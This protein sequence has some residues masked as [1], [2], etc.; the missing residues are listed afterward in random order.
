MASVA[1]PL[2]ADRYVGAPYDENARIGSVERGFSCWGLFAAVRREVFAS[3][4]ADYDGPMLNGRARN[5]DE[6][7][8]AAAAFASR[9]APVAPGAER[10]GDAVLLRLRGAPIHIGIV[11][12]PGWMLHVDGPAGAAIEPYLTGEWAHRIIGFYRE[13]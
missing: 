12:R 2:W 6:V 13:Q 5:A 1:Q 9:F 4:I 10:E 3:S 7:G 8:A 11:T